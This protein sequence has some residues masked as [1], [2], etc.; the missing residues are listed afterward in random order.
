MSTMRNA[1]RHT[2][3]TPRKTAVAQRRAAMSQ[4]LSAMR[5]GA[6][7]PIPSITR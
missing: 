1:R 7:V 4:R 6:A 2:G 3:T 5:V